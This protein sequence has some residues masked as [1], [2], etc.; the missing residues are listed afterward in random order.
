MWMAVQ[1]TQCGKSSILKL[2]TDFIFQDTV[3]SNHF[4]KEVF[5]HMRVHCRQGVIQQ[6][7]V[8]LTVSGSSQANTLFL[9][10]GDIDA[11]RTQRLSLEMINNSSS[12]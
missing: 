3:R 10:P 5:C 7:D 9:T 1:K 2:G 12:V 4:I 6:I 8:S 11:L